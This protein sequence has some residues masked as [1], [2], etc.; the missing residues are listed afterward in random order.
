MAEMRTKSQSPAA[1]KAGNRSNCSTGKQ[2][3]QRFERFDILEHLDLLEPTKR[4]NFYHCP[5]CGKNDFHVNPMDGKFACFSGGCSSD[6]IVEAL[7]RKAGT[8]EERGSGSKTPLTSS[9]P[10]ASLWTGIPCLFKQYQIT[11]TA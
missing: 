7:K 3:G 8:W 10:A 4:K 9:P 1:Q 2:S 6:S 5:N 11:I